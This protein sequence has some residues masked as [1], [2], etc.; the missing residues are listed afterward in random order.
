MEKLE[1]ERDIK[2][3]RPLD[4]MQKLL[5]MLENSVSL[6]SCVTS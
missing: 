1:R 2:E 3:K 6:C 5:N 4:M